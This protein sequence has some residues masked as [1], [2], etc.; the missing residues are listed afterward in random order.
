MLSLKKS[1]VNEYWKKQDSR[2]SRIFTVMEN[3]EHWTVDE[4]ESVSRALEDLAIKINK[5]SKAKIGDIS[6]EMIQLMAYISSSKSSRILNWM[7]ETHPGISVHY[8]MKSKELENWP[9]AE[10]LIDRLQTIKSL[11]LMSKVFTPSRTRIISELLKEEK[12]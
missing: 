1:I 12:L 6:E 3:V 5:A 9:E 8:V 2:L 4:V 7:D 11:S 10:I